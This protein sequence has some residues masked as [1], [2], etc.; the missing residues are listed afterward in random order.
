MATREFRPADHVRFLLFLRSDRARTLRALLVGEE[1]RIVGETSFTLEARRGVVL[2]MT[3]FL[4]T[5][6]TPQGRYHL[7][8]EAEGG[9]LEV[10]EVRV[11]R[12]VESRPPVRV[13]RIEHPMA[14]RFGDSIRLL[15]Y[16][17]RGARGDRIQPGTTLHL[18]LYWETEAPIAED[19]HVFTHLVGTAY[20]PRTEGPLWAQDDQIPLE[21]TYPTYDWL[22]NLPLAD[23]Y[24]LE[25]PPD[26]PPGDYWLTVGLYREDGERLPVEG[27]APSP[28]ERS[29]LLLVLHAGE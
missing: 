1:G 8:L 2:R 23:E 29:A 21:G 14:V 15:G 27:S 6:Y 17:L 26:L 24:E 9:S 16:D 12:G 13:E 22:P 3:D 19:L 11:T 28:D 5:P 25:L 4:I 10:G 18:T 20:N 7:R